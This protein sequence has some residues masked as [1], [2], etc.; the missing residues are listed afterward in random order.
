MHGIN[1]S[2]RLLE[3]SDYYY[4]TDCGLVGKC[5]ATSITT[6]R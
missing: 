3:C 5:M 4:G 6:D 1:D 2:L